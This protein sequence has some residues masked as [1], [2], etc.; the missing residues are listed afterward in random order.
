MERERQVEGRHHSMVV[1]GLDRRNSPALSKPMIRERAVEVKCVSSSCH[2]TG[3]L[4]NAVS[5]I[6]VDSDGGVNHG[7][8]KAV[9]VPKREQLRDPCGAQPLGFALDVSLAR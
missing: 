7:A 3:R 4:V 8:E 2:R 6:L 1:T 5:V 9:V